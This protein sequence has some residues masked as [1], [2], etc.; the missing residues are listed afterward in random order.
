MLKRVRDFPVSR[1]LSV[2]THT[3]VV[4]TLHCE[5]GL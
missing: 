2:E 1:N 3:V 4:K 5:S